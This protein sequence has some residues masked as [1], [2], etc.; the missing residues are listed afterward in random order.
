MPD[1]SPI[2]IVI[3]ATDLASVAR[4]LAMTVTPIDYDNP[5]KRTGAIRFRPANV[6]EYAKL[7][8]EL[9]PAALA[10]LIDRDFNGHLQSAFDLSRI[11]V[12]I[13]HVELIDDIATV[14][15]FIRRKQ[16]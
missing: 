6:A 13:P 9:S 14:K 1:S 12:I 16:A 3:N 2:P 5:V 7:S 4:A 15:I 10:E 11:E 8:S